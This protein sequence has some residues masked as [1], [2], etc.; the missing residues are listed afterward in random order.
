VQPPAE[1]GPDGLVRAAEAVGGR[2]DRLV[3]VAV[4]GAQVER[5]LVAERRVEAGAVEAELVDEVRTVG[6]DIG[7]GAVG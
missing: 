1:R 6:T 3:D 5:V 4:Q 2:G 7:A